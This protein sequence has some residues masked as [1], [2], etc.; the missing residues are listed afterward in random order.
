MVTSSESN[1]QC[2][3]SMSKIRLTFGVGNTLKGVL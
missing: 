3:A 1:G 2:Q